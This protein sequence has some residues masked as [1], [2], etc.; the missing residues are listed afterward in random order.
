MRILTLFFL[1]LTVACKPQT[2]KKDNMKVDPHSHAN[3]TWATL[4]HLSWSASIDFDTKTIRAKATWTI[5]SV[6]DAQE[7]ILDVKSMQIDRVTL[8][9]DLPAKFLLGP[10]DNIMGQA[11]HI[12]ISPGT[13]HINIYYQTQPASEA[14]Q[15][16]SPQQTTGKKYPFLFTQSEA[17]LARSWI[18]CQDSPG[19]RFTYDAAVTVPSDL[20]ALMSASNPQQKNDSGKYTFEMKQPIPSYLLA[21]AVGDISFKPIS[22]RSG[23]YAEPAVL[24]TAAWEFAA[25][26]K[27]IEVAEQLY[28]PYRWERY[29]VIVLPPSFPF[30]GMENPRLTFVTPTLL[31]G[32]RSLTSVIAHE[33]A[34]SWSGNLVTNKT[35]NDFWLNE[36]FTVYFETRIMEKL[37]GRDYAEMLASLNLHSLREE[38]NTIEAGPHPED[39]RLKLD[40]TGRNPDDAA[41]DVAY[42]KG[43]F[44]LRTIEEKFGREKFDAFLKDYFSENA[45]SAMNTEGFIEFIKNYYRQSY[46]IAL[47]DP[48]FK[49]WIYSEGLPQDC[50]IP[51]S[52]RFAKVESAISQWS[53]DGK[54]S[55]E[56]Y[57]TWSTQEWLHFLN[58]LPDSVSMNQMREL[59][60]LGHFNE[61]G[62]AEIF[63]VWGVL[64]IKN[65]YEKAYP[66]V[67]KFLVHTGRRKFLTPLYTELIKTEKGRALA[68]SI[69]DEAR[70]NYH[71]VATNTLDKLLSV[72]P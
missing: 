7:I 10:E 17:I 66:Y 57:E 61:T 6:Q 32:D 8:D 60:E 44:F 43:Y 62:N 12:P 71:F 35:W 26:E 11:L 51:Q 63:C 54:L 68:L 2:E 22:P 14:L 19:V 67:R 65:K 20:I 52:Q 23:V 24:D 31:A 45:F 58:N 29:D 34:H 56:T 30:G 13:E 28:G 47:E 59:E 3:P 18:P 37:Y 50:P 55:P 70:P 46:N 33:L 48:F 5:E 38:M 40:L 72:T 25:L 16:L 27:M 4:K 36:G 64:A 41:T 69:Y 9:N 15:W 53:Q 42:D 49:E 1:F 39:T 21:L